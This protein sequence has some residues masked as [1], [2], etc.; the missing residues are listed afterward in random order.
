MFTTTGL[1]ADGEPTALWRVSA[2]TGYISVAGTVR[3]DVIDPSLGT[4]EAGGAVWVTDGITTAIRSSQVQF[5][6]YGSGTDY[7]FSG[8]YIHGS[9]VA[10]Q[11][12]MWQVGS[13]NVRESTLDVKTF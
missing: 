6:S 7:Q 10:S 5:A 12:G 11:V 8:T 13:S 3:A 4:L 2:G 9:V 1:A